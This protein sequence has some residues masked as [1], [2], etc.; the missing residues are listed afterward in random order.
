MNLSKPTLLIDFKKVNRNIKRIAEKGILSNAKIVPH[1]KTHQSLQVGEIFRKNGIA[2]ITVSS[3]SM[4]NYFANAGWTII[5]IAFPVNILEIDAINKLSAKV[6]LTLLINNHDQ[7]KVLVNKL[8][9][10]VNVKIEIDCGSNRSGL[11]PSDFETIDALLEALNSSRHIFDGFYSHFG[12][13]YQADSAR[14]VITIFNRSIQHLF[15][16]KDHYSKFDPKISTGDTP[17]ASLIEKFKGLDSVHAGNYVFY[18]LTQAQ[19]GVCTEDDIAI[20]LAC[21]VVSKNHETKELVLYGGGI[22]LSKENMHSREFGT[23]V[24]GKLVKLTADGWS[25]S[26]EDSFIRALSQEHGIAKV[27]SKLFDE[28]NVGDIIGVLPVHSCMTADCMRGYTDLQGNRID[29]LQG[30]AV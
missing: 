4:A 30:L 26:I 16:L 25:K 28:I 10:S 24:F 18:D 3:V 12:H 9:H 14:E 27:S 15:D 17:S 11:S 21:P 23:A 6:D 22:H 19:I 13:T 5:Y 8:S 29:H 7:L 20:A 2:A 1:F